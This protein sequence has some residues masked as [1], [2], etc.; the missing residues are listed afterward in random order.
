[1]SLVSKHYSYSVM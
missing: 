1:V